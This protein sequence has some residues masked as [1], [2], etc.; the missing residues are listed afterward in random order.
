MPIW[1]TSWCV[2][3]F[4]YVAISGGCAESSH[5]MASSPAPVLPLSAASVA[6]T[7][8]AEKVAEDSPRADAPATEFSFGTLGV[9]ESGRHTFLVRNRGK[10]PL[11]LK[12]GEVSC[13]CT[14]AELSSSSVA[15]G[16]TAEVALE[17]KTEAESG[18]FHQWVR[19]AT[20][21]PKRREIALHIRGLVKPAI[22]FSPAEIEF[23]EIAPT[24]SERTVETLLLSDIA[25]GFSLLEVKA[26]DPRLSVQSEPLSA[27]DLKEHAAVAGYRLRVALPED[28]PSGEL[29]GVLD[30]VLQVPSKTEPEWHSLPLHARVL[31]RI[32]VLG[33]IDDYG[34]VEIGALPYGKGA[35]KRLKLKV[36][37]PEGDLQ[38]AALKVVPEFMKVSLVPSKSA[39]VSGL[40]DLVV[41]IPPETEPCVH[42]VRD[43]GTIHFDFDHPRIKTLDLGVSFSVRPPRELP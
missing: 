29:N 39:T 1:K 15:P 12:V 9:Y 30:V 5:P 13:K 23:G 40:Y 25:D 14:S 35:V 10:Q 43:A 11:E 24:A 16:E 4:V 6:V 31:G 37:D 22:R 20:N 42:R 41:E 32:S 19:I 18:P 21:D 3:L 8:A 17:W 28:F 26:F 33:E 7:V 2:L 38:I 36:R 27:A 34:C